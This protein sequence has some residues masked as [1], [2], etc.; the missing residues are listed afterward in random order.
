MVT[1]GWNPRC[2]KAGL[3]VRWAMRRHGLNRRWGTGQ[4]SNRDDTGE[5]GL[6]RQLYNGCRRVA[7]AMDSHRV[8]DREHRWLE[9]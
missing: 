6:V 9:S 1:A 3:L 5:T 2:R 4:D 7:N 8:S